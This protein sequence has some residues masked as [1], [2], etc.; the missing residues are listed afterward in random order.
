MCDELDVSL[1]YLV[2]VQFFSSLVGFLFMG[3][4]MVEVVTAAPS[5]FKGLRDL[6]DTTV[7]ALS[8]CAWCVRWVRARREAC[9]HHLF[10]ACQ[11]TRTTLLVLSSSFISRSHQCAYKAIVGHIVFEMLL[12]AFCVRCVFFTGLSK[13]TCD[14]RLV[15]AVIW[16]MKAQVSPRLLSIKRH[17]CYRAVRARQSRLLFASCPS[18]LRPCSFAAPL[19]PRCALA[20]LQ[21]PLI[22][23]KSLMHI[24]FPLWQWNMNRN[25][26]YPDLEERVRKGAVD[27]PGQ[28]I[29]S[30]LLYGWAPIAHATAHLTLARARVQTVAAQTNHRVATPQRMPFCLLRWAP[31]TLRA[32]RQRRSP[33][34]SGSCSS[35]KAAGRS[36]P[37]GTRSRERGWSG[38]GCAPCGP[39]KRPTAGLSGS[40]TRW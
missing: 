34:G 31:G 6:R 9:P 39:S 15:K 11:L 40:W 32:S 38:G 22:L 25:F 27:K 12:F 17:S 3:P 35:R 14:W 29:T 23:W 26:R 37:T 24:A 30:S 18:S 33:S 13:L 10:L 7:R 16:M 8:P 21:V 20:P 1:P 2:V 5:Y 36:R 28:V 4:A 19:L